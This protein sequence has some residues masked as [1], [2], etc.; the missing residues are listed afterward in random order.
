ME[1]SGQLHTSTALPPA[2]D[3]PLPI[4]SEW[5]VARASLD[6]F[7]AENNLLSWEGFELVHNRTS[8]M[9]THYYY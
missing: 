9:T 8:G 3:P 6:V 7:G 2:K 5:V 1:M 4:E